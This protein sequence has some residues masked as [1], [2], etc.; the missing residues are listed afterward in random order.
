VSVF[1]YFGVDREWHLA[2]LRVIT[3]R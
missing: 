2:N 1:H 3:D